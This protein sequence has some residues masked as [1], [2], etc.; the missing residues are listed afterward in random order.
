METFPWKQWLLT[1]EKP[2]SFGAAGTFARFLSGLTRPDAVEILYVDEDPEHLAGASRTQVDACRNHFNLMGTEVDF[3]FLHGHF[4]KNAAHFSEAHPQGLIICGAERVNGFR[5]FWNGSETYKL[6][7]LAKVPVISL[8]EEFKK[9]TIKR[10]VVP[11]DSSPE[12]TE[13]VTEAIHLATFFN[14]EIHMIALDSGKNVEFRNMLQTNMYRAEALLKASGIPFHS[15][16]FTGNNLTDITLQYC[17][18]H[19]IDMVIMMAVEEANPKGMFEGSFPEQMILKS[20]I[21]VM[22]IRPAREIL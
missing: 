9:E 17:D 13:K 14:A 16:Q 5:R 3:H 4:T 15:R 2:E 8:Q 18:D 11:V 7:R 1:A 6:I 10:L 21:P 22:A 12:S 20:H 19:D